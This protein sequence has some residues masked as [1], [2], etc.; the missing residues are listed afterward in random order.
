MTLSEE[1]E[2]ALNVALAEAGRRRHEFAEVEHLLYALLHDAE[3]KE[4]LR[5]C[6]ADV[7]SIKD[8]LDAH[9]REKVAQSPASRRLQVAPSRGFERVIER[10]AAHAQSAAKEKVSGPNV[11]VAIFA[12]TDSFAAY[13]LGKSGV[14]RLDVV[15][16]LSHGISKLEGRAGR[17]DAGAGGKEG[18]GGDADVESEDGATATDALE[19][20]TTNLNALA[21]EGRI[22]PLI[23]REKE[24]Q[25]AIHILARRR[26]HHPLLVG[27]AG[28]GK[29]AIVEG[30]ALAIVN[31]TVPEVLHNAEIF[32]LDMGQL[33]AGTRNATSLCDHPKIVQVLVIDARHKKFTDYQYIV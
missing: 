25:R 23:G 26:K 27:E 17:E 12:E 1:L 10:A 3:T 18:A 16:F 2:I 22:D 29:T 28:V 8:Q 7:G 13:L 32:S 21:R 6:G 14:R 9:L 5:H 4:V 30:L 11:L 24:L 33:L 20:Y 15:R 19:A 31:K